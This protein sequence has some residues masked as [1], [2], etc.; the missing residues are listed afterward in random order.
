S[1]I[2]LLNGSVSDGGSLEVGGTSKVYLTG[3]I[4]GTLAVNLGGI[5]TTF[6]Q[7]L[8]GTAIQGSVEGLAKVL[9]TAGTCSVRS[10][11]QSILGNPFVDPCRKAQAGGPPLVFPTWS[12][13]LQVKGESQCKSDEAVSSP[14]APVSVDLSIP[15]TTTSSG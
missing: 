11:F 3:A 5:S 10:P 8:P 7:G 9:F 6:V 13:G 1:S 4:G 15:T 14:L 2:V 12:C